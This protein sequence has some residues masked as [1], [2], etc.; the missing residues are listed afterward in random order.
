MGRSELFKLEPFHRVGG[1]CLSLSLVSEIN[2][3]LTHSVQSMGMDM[4]D[5][6]NL[7]SHVTSS[8]AYQDL[9]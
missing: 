3:P 7:Q 9:H 8:S 2:N 1:E 6:T 5:T 4:V